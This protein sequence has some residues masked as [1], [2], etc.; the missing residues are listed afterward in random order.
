VGTLSPG[1]KVSINPAEWK[2]GDQLPGGFSEWL[3]GVVREQE[4][5][6]RKG[7]SRIAGEL[8][9]SP[10]ILSR[11]LAGWGP[12]NEHDFNLLASKLGNVVYTYL[13]IPHPE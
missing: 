5:E 2:S 11:W 1:E 9:V 3:R 8:G 10:S 12:M 13:H 6:Q 7:F 4:I